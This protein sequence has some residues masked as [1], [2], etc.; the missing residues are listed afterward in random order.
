MRAKAAVSSPT[1][2]IS[3][4]VLPNGTLIELIRSKQ[5]PDG[6]G[7]LRWRG[8]RGALARRIRFRDRVFVPV[9]IEA[10]V[11]R[12]VRFA[13]GVRDHGGVRD[14]FRRL[15]EVIAKQCDLTD[16]DVRKTVYW[17]LSSWFPD[18]FISPPGLVV[19]SVSPV[20]ASC[21]LGLLRCFCRRGLRLAELTTGGLGA[22]PTQLQ[23]TL[24]LDQTRVDRSLSGVL[25]AACIQGQ[26]FLTPG[27]LREL[28]SAKAVFCAGSTPKPFSTEAT[29]TVALTPRESSRG[30]LDNRQLDALADEY[31]PRLLHYRLTSYNRVRDCTFDVPGFTPGLRVLARSLGAAVLG[32]EELTSE[33][34]S[35][36]S[37]QDADA[38]ARR[39]LLPESA[40]VT[41]ALALLHGRRPTQML[42]KDFTA[43]VNALL[44][45]NGEITEYSAEEL[46]WVLNRLGLY[47]RRMTGGRGLRFDREFSKLV[48]DLARAFELEMTPGRYPGCPDCP[49]SGEV[50][51]NKLLK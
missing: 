30:L 23:P 46:G 35:L 1:V 26:F 6:F 15:A 47:S 4:A 48:H 12:A 32:D 39:G 3:A 40:V 21:F 24:L 36:L 16:N 5:A 13:S 31:Q 41:T 28:H 8:R 17:T 14:L 34:V 20:L 22:L 51:E 2:P 18:L 9:P 27:G 25:R 38:R 44:R 7:L 37:P 42:I 49:Q 50:D 29:L 19:A 33:L 43:L 45:A 11:S 10:V